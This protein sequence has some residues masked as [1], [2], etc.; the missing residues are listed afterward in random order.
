MRAHVRTGTLNIWACLTSFMSIEKTLVGSFPESSSPLG[1]AIRE[2][3]DLQLYYGIDLIT[4]GE[5]RNNMIQYFEQIPGLERIGNGLR[6]VGKVEPIQ[7]DK[8]DEFYKIIDYKTVKSFLQSMGKES[9]KTKITITGPMTLG[10]ACASAD[11]NSTLEHYDLDDEKALYSDF[12]RALLP[13]AQRAL[14]IGAHVQIDESLLSTGQVSLDSAK[15]ILKDF[16]SRLPFFSIE[17]ERVSC[18]VCGS[19]KSVTGLYDVLL[20]LEFPIL[21]IGFSGEKE[22][23]NFDIISG[24]SLEDACMQIRFILGKTE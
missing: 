10:T 13:L 15:E 9:A 23:E 4:D 14:N 12:S 11:I 20:G 5:M 22:K 21:S 24:E 3:V 7:R 18:H 6:I 16:T 19:I 1:K 17:E 2:V 8:I